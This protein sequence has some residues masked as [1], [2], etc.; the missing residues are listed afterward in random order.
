MS[1]PR[2]SLASEAQAPSSTAP[3]STRSRGPRGARRP[4][5]SFHQGSTHSPTTT[6]CTSF[7]QDHSL[8]AAGLQDGF[9][10]YSADPL[11]LKKRKV[12]P[13]NLGGGGIGLVEMLWRTNYL[14]LVGGGKEPRWPPNKVIIWDD[15]K[16]RGIIEL[17]FRSEVKAVRLRRD[18]IVVA[19]TTRVFIYSL[20]VPPKRLHTF[21]TGE[22]EHGLLALSS[23]TIPIILAFPARQRGGRVGGGIV[24]KAASWQ[25][26][27]TFLVSAHTAPLSA[28]A[29]SADGSLTA[30]ASVKGTLIR[31]F[32][33]SSGRLLHEL[34]RGADRAEIY[35]IAFSQDASR[36]CVSSDKGTV[37]IFNLDGTGPTQV[38][39]GLTSSSSSPSISLSSSGN[40]QSTLSFMKDILPK[41]FSSEWS[42]AH[43]RVL[44]ETRCVCGFG[45]DNRTIIGKSFL[46]RMREREREEERKR[47][48]EGNYQDFGSS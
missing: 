29:I 36:L 15:A 26:N 31:V 13:A 6:L 23:A 40:R 35:H 48:G 17:E 8:F 39:S 9:R 38:S 41:Y 30:S 19:L 7:N 44:G 18:R 10:I 11:S 27:R 22:N 5:P 37:H 3:R 21:E 16:G 24:P 45:K 47:G 20:S 25:S 46:F 43:C 12:F 28:L 32:E 1:L 34:R 33:T 14:A 42:F 2:D 4:T